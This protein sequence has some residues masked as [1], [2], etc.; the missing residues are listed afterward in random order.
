MDLYLLMIKEETKSKREENA[1][2]SLSWDVGV[3][4]PHKI[5]NREETGSRRRQDKAALKPFDP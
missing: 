4:Y 1:F 5:S 2:I 3:F